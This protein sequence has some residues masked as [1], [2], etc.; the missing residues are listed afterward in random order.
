MRRPS[1]SGIPLACAIFLLVPGC[2]EQSDGCS[3]MS[4]G[5][6]R[7]L[8]ASAYREMAGRSTD[9]DATTEIGWDSRPPTYYATRSPLWDLDF[10]VQGRDGN[11][12]AMT[13]MLM[14]SGDV[15][16]SSSR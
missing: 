8:V 7:R 1:L 3:D 14:C 10:H 12:R 9:L 4:E 16:F 11:S 5:E 13:A 2:Q 6:I 15:E